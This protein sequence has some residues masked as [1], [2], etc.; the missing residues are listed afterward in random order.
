VR[1]L[2]PNL[3]HYIRE[4]VNRSSIV[5]F[6]AFLCVSSAHAQHKKPKPTPCPG[7]TEISDCP[8]EGCGKGADAKLNEAKNT[9][10]PD[11]TTPT[12]KT[13]QWWKELKNPRGANCRNR[14]KLR[15][16]GEG[17]MITVV[18]WALAA[19][20]EGGE[21]CNCKL[22]EPKD[23]DN[24]IVLVDPKFKSPTLGRNEG[25]SVTA[26]FTPRVRLDH[27]N[28]TQE[29]LQ[30]LIDPTWEPGQK[31][32]K[33]KLLVRVTG[34]LMFDS[35]HYCGPFQLKRENDWEIHPVFKM[36]YCPKG[37]KCT[38]A[39]DENWVDFE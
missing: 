12:L 22:S 20:A 38:G 33:G 7:I 9:R 15:E 8:A 13:V 11:G 24:H 16:L 34:R 6:N 21:T 10:V 30:S 31:P 32:Q 39:S 1:N 18:A 36:E 37:M 2:T 19:R 23:T 4:A 3:T 14:E 35:E 29:K 25:H 27:P 5:L 17:Q 26:E 28:F